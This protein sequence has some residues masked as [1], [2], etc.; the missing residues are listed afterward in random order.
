MYIWELDLKNINLFTNEFLLFSIL[1]HDVTEINGNEQLVQKT[2]CYLI[3]AFHSNGES[4]R[5]EV[6]ERKFQGIPTKA[7][8]I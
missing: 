4:R 8:M 6:R 7:K 5:H 1:E 3:Q 2:Y